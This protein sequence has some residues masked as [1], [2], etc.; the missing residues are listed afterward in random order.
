MAKAP[1]CLKFA[2]SF[3]IRCDFTAKFALDPIILFD[4]F[5]KTIH[6]RRQQIFGLFCRIDT[7]HLEDFSPR[8][9]ADPEYIRERILDSFFVRNIYAYDTHTL[10][11]F[12]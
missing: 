1:V 4:D 7:S 9:K 11:N 3:D 10:S 6:F 2:H 5:A 12:I 8:R